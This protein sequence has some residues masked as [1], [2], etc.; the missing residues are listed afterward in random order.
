M[1]LV[2]NELMAVCECINVS[3]RY[4]VV[5][6]GNL[7]CI[8]VYLPC[9]G[10]LDRDLIY[11]AVLDELCYWRNEYADCSCNIGG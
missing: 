3:E 10:T 11:E 4:V 5:K 8:N 1:I 9:S 2:K 6:V 7:L